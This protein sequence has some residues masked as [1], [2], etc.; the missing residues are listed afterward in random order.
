MSRK[1]RRKTYLG[2]AF[3]ALALS[4]LV[5]G[6]AHAAEPAA[7]TPDSEPNR[8]IYV[9]GPSPKPDNSARVIQ[10]DSNATVTVTEPEDLPVVPEPGETVRI[11]Y[12]DAVTEITTDPVVD[13]VGARAGACTKSITAN[14]PWKSSTQARASGSGTISRGCGYGSTLRVHLYG[15]GVH[16]GDTS[17]SVPNNGSTFSTGFGRT[18]SNSNSTSHYVLSTWSSGGSAMSGTRTLACGYGFWEW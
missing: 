18:C 10:S 13:S 17:F 14:T 5:S 3:C 15:G 12:T 6:P 4:F 16:R 2:G 8:I 7:P 11:I 9:D 1:L